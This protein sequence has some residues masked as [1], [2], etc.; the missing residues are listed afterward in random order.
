MSLSISFTNVSSGMFNMLGFIIAFWSTPN[1]TMSHFVFAAT[2]T[3]YIFVAITYLEERDL[4]NMHG[5]QYKEY[6]S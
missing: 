1:M 2:T 4:V 6:Q 3:V 5:A